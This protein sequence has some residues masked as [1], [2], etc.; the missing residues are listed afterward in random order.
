MG[1]L[2]G[3]RRGL[4][5]VGLR[6]ALLVQLAHTEPRYVVEFF[7]FLCVLGGIALARLAP[8]SPDGVPQ[9][10]CGASVPAFSQK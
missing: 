3:R 5:L 2:A 9:P 1:V 7:P 6:L 4:A 8:V 10:G